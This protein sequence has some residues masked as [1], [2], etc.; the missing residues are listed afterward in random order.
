MGTP[1]WTL[2]REKICPKQLLAVPASPAAAPLPVRRVRER[3]LGLAAALILLL[4]AFA[5]DYLTGEQ[6]SFSIC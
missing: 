3:P 4:A 2:D 6:V 1:A 5:G